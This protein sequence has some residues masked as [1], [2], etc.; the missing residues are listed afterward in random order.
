MNQQKHTILSSWLLIRSYLKSM[1]WSTIARMDFLTSNM[2][3]IFFCVLLTMLYIANGH[4]AE[5][6][7][8]GIDRASQQVKEAKW[9]YMTAK[10]ELMFNSKQ[11]QVAQR[12]EKLG[13]RELRNPPIKIKP[14]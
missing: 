10:S 13:L 7:I 14:D 9:N 5:R 2:P 4:L 8:R 3:F 1:S 12:V 11:T 6:T